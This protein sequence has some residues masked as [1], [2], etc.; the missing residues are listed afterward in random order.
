MKYL[1]RNSL[2]VNNWLTSLPLDPKLTTELNDG[3]RR[4]CVWLLCLSPL[5]P[6]GGWV[7]YGAGVCV[8]VGAGCSTVQ[9]SS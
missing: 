2:E 7:L 6:V 4:G 8:F 9:G 5:C 3:L 1:G